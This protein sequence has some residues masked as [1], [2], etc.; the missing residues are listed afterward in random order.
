MENLHRPQC[1]YCE[2]E[3]DDEQIW[4]SDSNGQVLTDDGDESK[5]ICPNDDCGKVFHVC[6]IHQFKFVNVDEDGSELFEPP[7]EEKEES[8]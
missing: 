8:Q 1:P 7:S 5:L 6:C 4:Y 2:T 3:F